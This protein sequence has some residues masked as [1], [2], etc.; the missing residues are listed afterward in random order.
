MGSNLRN[1]VHGLVLSVVALI[2]FAPCVL[3][4]APAAS[5]GAAPA[6]GL[7]TEVNNELPDW[8]RFGGEYRLRWEGREGIGGIEE[9]GDQF[10]LSRLRLDL[11]FKI[12]DHVRLFVQGQ[13]SQVWDHDA[14]PDPPAVENTFDLRQAWIQIQEQ[15]GKGWSLRVGRQ[16][17][18]YGDHRLVGSFNW[19][20]VGRTFDAAKLN[21]TNS[22]VSVDVFGSSVV[23][24]EDDDFDKLDDG[25]NFYGVHA[26]FPQAVPKAELNAYTFWKT[27][28]LVV[29]ERGVKGDA[30]T[31]TIG[32][33]LNGKLPNDFDYTTE[34]MFQTGDFGGDDI[35]AGALHARL[36]YQFNAAGSPKLRFEYNFAS[37][38]GETG[39]GTRGTFDQLYPTNHDKYGIMDLVG[40]RNMHDL[41]TGVLFK[42]TK[43]F[44]LE[45][46]YHSFW[47]ADRN[48]GLYN[49][50]G[51]LVARIPGGS[52]FSHI[53]QEFDVQGTYRLGWGVTFGA[54]YGHWFPGDFWEAATKGAP[55][56]WG[57]AQMT[58]KF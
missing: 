33:R 14:N 25:F 38:D 53:A 27:T 36:G 51:A 15:D 54:G 13:D 6:P 45:F 55:Q 8:V 1:T 21:F 52:P 42:P 12:G 3:A 10:G 44:D 18:A 30:D 5:T 32:G 29:D 24:I 46:D 43:K 47:L 17:L 37:G 22:V 41:R 23:V 4:Q 28:P 57:Y 9:A 26:T 7:A 31:V 2:L 35:K 40:L 34:V 49:A 16:E 56:D 58:Y 11:T 20:N 39:D 19:S 50:A 48:D